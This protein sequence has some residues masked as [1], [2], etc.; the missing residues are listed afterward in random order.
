[1]FKRL[2]Y[3]EWQA[4]IPMIAFCLTFGGFLVFT[5]RALVM[6]GQNANDMAYLPLEE[7]SNPSASPKKDV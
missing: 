1:M 2:S 4:L 3:D 6:R 7:S 5:I